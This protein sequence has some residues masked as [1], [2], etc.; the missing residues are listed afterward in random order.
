MTMTDFW[1]IAL[2]SLVEVDS[3]SEVLSAS[4]K[5][6]VEAG[7]DTETFVSCTSLHGAKSQKAAIIIA[8]VL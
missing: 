8:Y 3:G 5:A 1:D 6:V 4:I 2:S 7:S